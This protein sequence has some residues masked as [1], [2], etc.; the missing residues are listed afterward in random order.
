VQ[1]E[2][3]R[4]TALRG[5]L[6]V[7][8]EPLWEAKVSD[9]NGTVWFSRW[10]DEDLWVLDAHFGPGGFPVFSNGLGSRCTAY[11]VL[12]KDDSVARVLDSLVEAAEAEGDK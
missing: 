9:E 12:P 1:Y 4:T 8:D 11:R 5:L 2:V 3:K 10:D 6:T 7:R